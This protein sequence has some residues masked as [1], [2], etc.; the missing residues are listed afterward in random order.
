MIGMPRV[1]FAAWLACAMVWRATPAAATVVAETPLP[2][3]VAGA[4]AI[5]QGRV[6]RVGQRLAVTESGLE[7]QRVVFV[8][9]ERWLKPPVSSPPA[10]VVLHEP[11]GVVAGRR[12]LV[13]GAPRY[14]VGEEV[15]A[16]LEADG[17]AATG[18]RTMNLA[19][20]KFAVTRGRDDRTSFVK[21]DAHG[22]TVA[23]WRADAMELRAAGDEPPMQLDAFVRFVH[24]V[25]AGLR[26]GRGP[27]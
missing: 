26:P 6:A 23:S 18:F 12:Y 3:M 15:I 16:F 27:R 19:L 7:P 8:A 24:A 9:V 5:V 21:R 22:I 2:D 14:R 13:E 4:D 11:G 25:L 10:V 20:G 1:A 17:T